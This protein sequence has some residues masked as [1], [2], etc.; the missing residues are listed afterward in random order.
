MIVEAQRN[1]YDYPPFFF[2]GILY[3]T[4]SMPVNKSGPLNKI[5][6]AARFDVTMPIGWPEVQIMRRRDNGMSYIAFTTN[7]TEP[8]PTGYLN[9]YEYDLSEAARFII[10]SQDMLNI[11]WHGDLSQDRFLLAYYN[12]Y[13]GAPFNNMVPMVS[14][15]VGD[16]DSDTDLQTLN[17]EDIII[18]ESPASDQPSTRAITSPPTSNTIISS[19]IASK[20]ST[21]STNTDINFIKSTV[22]DKAKDKLSVVISGIISCSLLLIIILTTI[23]VTICFIALRQKRKSASMI[24][25]IEMNRYRYANQAQIFHSKTII[26]V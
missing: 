4:I 6:I 7:T 9:L 5:I 17:C 22:N 23:V 12:C 13:N 24:A 18:A 10:K 1:M 26:F 15:V 14:I 11:T 21:G 3:H 20:K 8:K 19:T 2:P 16:Y 25:T